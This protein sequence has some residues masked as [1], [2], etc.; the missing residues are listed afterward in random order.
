MQVMRVLLPVLPEI[1]SLHGFFGLH[2]GV[3]GYGFTYFG[4]QVV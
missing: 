4:V 2:L 3:L 1:E